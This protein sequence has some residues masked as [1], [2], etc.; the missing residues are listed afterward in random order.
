VPCRSFNLALR[1]FLIAVLLTAS[2]PVSA[3]ATR[4][5]QLAALA[6]TMARLPANPPDDDPTRGARPELTTAK[7]QLRDWIVAQLRAGNFADPSRAGAKSMTT[8]LRHKLKAAGIGPLGLSVWRSGPLVVA[9]TSFSIQCGSDASL[10][11]WLWN[12]HDWVESFT[13]ERNDYTGKYQPLSLDSIR[14]AADGAGPEAGFYVLASSVGTWC[15]S[16]WLGRMYQLFHVDGSTGKAQLLADQDL[17]AFVG[18]GERGAELSANYAVIKYTGDSVDDRKMP[19]GNKLVMYRLSNGKA[20]RVPMAAADAEDFAEQWLSAPRFAGNSALAPWWRTLQA[21]MAK[22]ESSEAIWSSTGPATRCSDN[23]RLWQFPVVF[24][25]T[26][27]VQASP[28]PR[29]DAAKRATESHAVYFL[30]HE[31]ARY[32]FSMRDISMKPRGNCLVMTEQ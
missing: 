18:E 15:S 30:V 28:G 9:S 13:Y 22:R 23:T 21:Y 26:A 24:K 16:N 3:K 27:M 6:A 31:D 2:L 4:D 11:G 1:L 8:I 29:V 10:Y 32:R 20:I 14:L 25:R 17:W 5:P 19:L 12:G 7:H